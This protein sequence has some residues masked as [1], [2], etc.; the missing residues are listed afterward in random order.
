MRAFRKVLAVL[1]LMAG[2]V[3]CGVFAAERTG[4]PLGHIDRVL[5][6][7][8]GHVASLACAAIAGLGILVVAIMTLAE[9]PEIT[10]VHPAGNPDIE[11]SLTALASAA[12]R[13][14]PG[15]DDVLI[16]SVEGR[17]AGKGRDEV[18]LTVEAIAFTD[19][20]LDTLAQRMQRRVE[21]ACEAL[22]GTPGVV[23]RIRFLPSKTTI[24]TKEV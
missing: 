15:E 19:Q 5:D 6:T 13:A 22:L 20:G 10:C 11:V 21:T 23:A 12:R 3:V 2:I 16:E 7:P 14:A 4:V 24:V 8:A 18:R 1:F 9:R 17:V